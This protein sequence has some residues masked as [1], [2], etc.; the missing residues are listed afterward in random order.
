MRTEL[1]I[2]SKKILE[3]S[4]ETLSTTILNFLFKDPEDLFNLPDQ[5]SKTVKFFF[6]LE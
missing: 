6:F 5:L 1:K 4:W 2:T 3:D